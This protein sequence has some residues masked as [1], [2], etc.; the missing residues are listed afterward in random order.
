MSMCVRSTQSLVGV[1]EFHHD[2]R[3]S[4]RRTEAMS[5]T[6]YPPLKRPSVRQ[7]TSK[8]RPAPMIK[9]VGFSISGMPIDHKLQST[10]HHT[11][12]RKISI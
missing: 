4:K 3:K 8:P 12:K 2:H 1:V 10:A 7:A 11:R 6:T 5:S 9:L